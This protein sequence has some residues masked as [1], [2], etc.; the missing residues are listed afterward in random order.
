MCVRDRFEVSFLEQYREIGKV[1]CTKNG[2]ILCLRGS[3]R[4]RVMPRKVVENR[5]IYNVFI[6]YRH[7]IILSARHA[8]VR[9]LG[10][11]MSDG[12]NNKLGKRRKVKL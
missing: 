6:F 3:S 7:H 2:Y 10:R 8:G 11:A 4:A 5:W 9:M 1:V 12:M